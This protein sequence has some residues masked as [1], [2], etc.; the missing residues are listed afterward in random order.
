MENTQALQCPKCGA[1]EI[2]CGKKWCICDSC[3]ERFLSD[4]S[5]EKRSLKLFFSYSHQEEEICSKIVEALRKRGHEIWFDREKIRPGNDWREEIANGILSSNG[6]IAFLSKTSVRDPG[7]CLN[8]LS[9]AIGVRGS[10]IK[11]VLLEPE[12]NV[13]PPSSISH[14]QWLDMSNWREE[15]AKGTSNFDT[16]F[17]KKMEELILTIESNE[18]HSFAGQLS[19]IQAALPLIHHD[20]SKQKSLLLQPFVGRRWLTEAVELWLNDPNQKNLCVLYGEPGIGKSTFAANYC[21]FN[22]KVVASIFCEYNRINFNKVQSVIQTLAYL[23]ACRLP[24]YRVIL[25]DVLN[26][27]PNIGELNASEM[28]DVLLTVPLVQCSIDGNHET[29][30]IVIDGIDE[31]GDVENNPLAIVLSQY[32]PRFP[33]WIRFLITARKLDSVRRALCDVPFLDLCGDTKENLKDVKEYFSQQ[34]NGYIKSNNCPENFIELLAE[35]SGGIFLYA[36]IVAHAFEQGNMTLQN[37]D[38]LPNGISGAFQNWFASYFGDTSE[39]TSKFRLPLGVLASSPEPIPLEEFM[40]LFSWNENDTADFIRRISMFIRQ[41]TNIFKQKTLAFS[42]KYLKDWLGSD[43]AGIYKSSHCAAFRY[44]GTA[45]YQYYKKSPENL[46]QFETLYLFSFLVKTNQTDILQ[47]LIQNPRLYFNINAIGDS[48]LEKGQLH[49]AWQYFSAAEEMASFLKEQSPT[50]DNRLIYSISEL[51]LAEIYESH[52]ALKKAFALYQ[53]CYDTRM[54]LNEE[55]GDAKDKKCLGVSCER[56]ATSHIAFGNTEEAK[57]LL[58]QGLAIREQLIAED[59]SAENNQNA[60]SNYIRLAELF[61]AEG[62]NNQASKLYMQCLETRRTQVKKRGNLNDIKDLMV[63]FIRAASFEFRVGNLKETER[64]IQEALLLID[65]ISENM[66]NAEVTRVLSFCYVYHG[67]LLRAK[68]A[69]KE[70]EELFLK[71]INLRKKLVVDRNSKEDL[72]NLGGAYFSLASLKYS[73]H[74]Y[75]QAKDITLK[76]LNIDEALVRERGK[77]EDSKG[78]FYCLLMLG[79]ISRKTQAL[80]EALDYFEKAEKI[81][82]NLYNT[83]NDFND[84]E[85][86]ASV[87]HNL[88]IIF[89]QLGDYTKSEEFCDK[90]LELRKY[91]VDHRGVCDDIKYYGASILIKS[92][93]HLR[94]KEYSSVE[95]CLLKVLDLDQE[96]ISNRGSASDYDCLCE[97]Y[98]RLAEF[99]ILI[100]STEKGREYSA[101][102]LS[103]AE[104]LCSMRNA[105]Q[106]QALLQQAKQLNDSL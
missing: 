63:S 89:Y 26:N 95:S 60:G 50:P 44:M 53:N 13:T 70:A 61:E 80:T 19:V 91:Q 8:E 14:I 84:R 82:K 104:H 38:S 30:C 106:D 24:E 94:R 29:I 18:S 37:L 57:A 40:R 11:T 1:D 49:K 17:A 47:E 56:L 32:V 67:E 2:I 71:G 64:L 72:W 69:I 90:A 9:I 92:R 20:T 51:K 59:N 42:H 22:S 97:A 3:G 74:E 15:K 28:F 77:A 39:Y 36:K 96:N 55:R 93:F 34:L 52:G 25:V 31:C 101:L 54:Q 76:I 48:C 23:L 7:V 102:A 58:Q 10:N 62:N 5:A 73:N 98:L 78:L 81:S 41:E 6:V 88:S 68:G 33:S 100:K 4:A 105:P 65:P 75:A 66:E 46:T 35:K 86:Y 103:C 12:N 87:L 85:D 83:R 43:S 27:T 99:Y 21:H 45:F 79:K 16:W